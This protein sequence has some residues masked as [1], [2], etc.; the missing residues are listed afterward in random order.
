MQA[1]VWLVR[2]GGR[3]WCP[4]VEVA[5]TARKLIFSK[6]E[7]SSLR[8]HYQCGSMRRPESIPIVH[9]TVCTDSSHGPIVVTEEKPLSP[10]RRKA[11]RGPIEYDPNGMFVAPN[12]EA[13]RRFLRAS[14]WSDGLSSALIKTLAKVPVRFIVCDD[15]GSML[16]TDGHRRIG[17]KVPTIPYTHTH[18]RTPQLFA[19]L[20]YLHVA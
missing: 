9:A 6:E 20:I 17:H 19:Q 15:S 11:K 5:E 12:E 7:S 3:R 13:C 1:A 8:R 10:S 4:V 14:G 18:R 16:S 2:T